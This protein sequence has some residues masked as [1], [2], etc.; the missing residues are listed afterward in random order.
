MCFLRL[1]VTP[2]TETGGVGALAEAAW[3]LETTGFMGWGKKSPA[4][5]GKPSP[6]DTLSLRGVHALAED[7][8]LEGGKV[9]KCQW[10]AS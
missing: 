5:L 9:S 7:S 10:W 4:C 6:I 8:D 2:A 3:Q 1:A